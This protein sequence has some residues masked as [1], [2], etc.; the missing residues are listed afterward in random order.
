MAECVLMKAGGGADLDAVTASAA[1]VVAP[2][3]IIGQDGEPLTGTMPDKKGTALTVPT[4][5]Q[6]LIPKGYHDGTQYAKNTQATMAG[7]TVT[8]ATGIQTVSCNGKLM[9]GNVVV[10]AIPNQ[11]SAGTHGVSSGINGNGLYYYVPQGYYLPDGSGNS[12]VYRTLSEIAST[13][14]IT[15]DKVKKGVSLCGVMGQWEG[16]IGGIN[17]LYYRGNNRAGFSGGNYVIF[18]TAQI[19]CGW[20]GSGMRHMVLTSD[21]I[22][23]TGYTKINLEIINTS[24]VSNKVEILLNTVREDGGESI[25]LNQIISG[26][27][28][29]SFELGVNGKRYIVIRWDAYRA[30]AITRIWLS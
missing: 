7:K 19:T 8:P 16:Y 21:L 17:D 11:N 2:K 28:V 6:A 4:N 24:V 13:L 18:D 10:G 5:G 22:E 9:T 20:T 27:Q 30:N 14:G 3:V 26:T 12:W 29:G 15:A 1:D 23:L 25:G